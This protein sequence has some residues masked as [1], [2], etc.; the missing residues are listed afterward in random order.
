MVNILTFFQQKINDYQSKRFVF[1]PCCDVGKH[2]NVRNSTT[3]ENL[4]I[5]HRFPTQSSEWSERPTCSEH[6][7]NPTQ[8]NSQPTSV[9]IGQCGHSQHDLSYYGTINLLR[10]TSEKNALD[11]RVLSPRKPSSLPAT[12]KHTTLKYNCLNE[13]IACTIKVYDG[14]PTGQMIHRRKSTHCCQ[15]QTAWTWRSRA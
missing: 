1:P 14:P 11:T 2:G 13:F 15:W 5:F 4:A 10:L 9:G 7:D 12:I 6:C 3:Y 8:L